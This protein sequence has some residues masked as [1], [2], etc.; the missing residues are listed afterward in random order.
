M[1]YKVIREVSK[2]LSPNILASVTDLH[3][4]RP[5]SW[6]YLKWFYRGATEQEILLSSMLLVDRGCEKHRAGCT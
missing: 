6:N 3:L 5:W 2:A 1:Q 4:C